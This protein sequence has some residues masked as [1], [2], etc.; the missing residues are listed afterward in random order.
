MQ[1]QSEKV[2]AAKLNM[3]QDIFYI[4][5]DT[6]DIT[7]SRTKKWYDVKSTTIKSMEAGTKSGKDTIVINKGTE[8]EF[9]VPITDE[10]TLFPTKNAALE[11]ATILNE[12]ARDSI[13]DEIEKLTK[14]H[15]FYQD[16]L[17]KVES[18]KI[19]K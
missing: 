6:V 8:N 9:E 14:V 5:E 11:E 19:Y 10:E 16:W 18:R 3:F 12:A 4:Q 15:D 17:E 2:P 7:K 1:K 13:A